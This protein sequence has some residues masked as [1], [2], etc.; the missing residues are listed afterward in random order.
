MTIKSDT[1]RLI[2]LMPSLAGGG[3]ERVASIMIPEFYRD[4]DLILVLLDASIDY[5][6]PDSIRPIILGR[7]ASSPVVHILRIPYQIA[8]ISQMVK[9]IKPIAVLSFME[10]ANI[11]NLLSSILT[12]HAAVLSQR[13]DP[14][15]QYEYKGLLGRAIMTSSRL[16]YKKAK[17]IICV[18]ERVK[19]RLEHEY[20][21]TETR[22]SVIPNPLNS[23][24]MDMDCLSTLSL[25]ETF[26]LQVG[27]LKTQAKGQDITIRAFSRLIR[28]HPN[29]HLV[30]AGEGPDR[31][32]L[33]QLAKKLG[34]YEKTRFLGWVKDPRPLMKK[35]LFL[36]HPSRYEGWPN[37]LAEALWCGC[38]IIAT[39]CGG[40]PEEMLEDGRFGMLIAPDNEKD[41]EKAMR[42]FL[43]NGELRKG[44][45]EAGRIRAR[46]FE[47]SK[48]ALR[49]KKAIEEAA[50]STD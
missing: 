34:V 3:A 39:R 24:P 25:P 14:R 42:L 50:L 4:F 11:I 47:P 44:F 10:Q 12:G 19:K 36:A 16:L 1:K 33:E 30:F 6:L 49:Y 40:G 38:P 37:V 5:K 31:Q 45:M 28:G 35:A 8:R 13:T 15:R 7:P 18:S 17:K 32:R 22:L 21:I 29:L 2:F 46:D 27:R 43:E 26:V 23:E 48:I 9:R 41:L 20:Q